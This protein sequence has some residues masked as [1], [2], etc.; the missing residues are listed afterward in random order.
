MPF[1]P[2]PKHREE[3][4]L[5]RILKKYTSCSA[6][7]NAKYNST[8][9]YHI[10]ERKKKLTVD[11]RL[12]NLGSTWACSFKTFSQGLKNKLY[13]NMSNVIGVYSVWLRLAVS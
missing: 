11:S 9:M 1:Y 3:V 7:L 4:H 8:S 2:L 5:S 13:L 12:Q 10:D 6:S